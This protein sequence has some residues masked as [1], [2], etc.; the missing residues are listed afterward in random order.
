MFC[1]IDYNNAY[2]TPWIVLTLPYSTNIQER[3]ISSN[4]CI[5]FLTVMVDRPDIRRHRRVLT[6][7]PEFDDPTNDPPD[8]NPADLDNVVKDNW[9]SIKGSMYQR[10]FQDILNCRLLRLDGDE[11]PERP[12]VSFLRVWGLHDCTFKVNI[13]FGVI[14]RHRTSDRLRYYHASSNNATVFPLAVR[15]SLRGEVDDLLQQYGDI[16]QASLGL[17]HRANSS[18]VLYRVTNVTFYVYKLDGVNRIG[19]A[20]ELPKHI[21]DSKSILSMNRSR[22]RGTLWNGNLCFFRCMAVDY[23]LDTD[24]QRLVQHPRQPS[25]HQQVTLRLLRHWLV[26]TN[27]NMHATRF[28]GV[29]LED[30]WELESLF[31][32]SI[33]VFDLHENKTSSYVNW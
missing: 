23:H 18:W 24:S 16:D 27:N 9:S 10:R 1:N 2:L 19:A 31:D 12:E 13:S 25:P 6:R 7:H 4:I 5:Y 32:I 15:V 30:L 8:V 11:D 20:P 26:H 28:P 22:Q 21:R 33:K 3:K 29:V 14:L 17:T